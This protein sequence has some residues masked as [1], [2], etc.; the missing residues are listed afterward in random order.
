MEEV[1]E[2]E[3]NLMHGGIMFNKIAERRSIYFIDAQFL[4]KIYN[5]LLNREGI[6]KKSFGSAFFSLYDIF[7]SGRWK[8]Q[9]IALT[10]L[11]L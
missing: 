10:M 6:E 3:E 2:Q 8:L 1:P 5:F 4:I 7:F 9:N 11:E